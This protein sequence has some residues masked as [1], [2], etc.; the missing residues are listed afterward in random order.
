MIIEPEIMSAFHIS[1]K[2]ALHYLQNDSLKSFNLL[3][4]SPPYKKKDGFDL[5]LMADIFGEAYHSAAP[6][7]LCFVNFGH[8]AH[9]KADPFRLALAIEDAGWKFHD[10]IVWVKNHYTPLP[11]PN[12]NNLW[13]PIFLF[14]KGPIKL[15]RL[16]LGVPY[17]DKSNV[18]RYGAGKDLRCAGNVWYVPYETIQSK[19][20][21]T[22]KDRFP[23]EIPRRCIKLSGLKRGLV[24]D[25][26]CGSA[27]TGIA[28]LEAGLAFVG[29]EILPDIAKA[30]HLR[31][32]KFKEELIVK[33]ENTCNH[34]H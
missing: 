6:S 21:K 7:C 8:L 23:V 20:Q 12:L 16:A 13:E 22:H 28:A 25:P 26:F 1:N 15:D 32:E 4:T 19:E 18:N 3:I 10:T 5:E 34:T 2:N 11:D 33:N 9:H 14:A 27:T 30:A 31:L 29:T 24:F 17:A